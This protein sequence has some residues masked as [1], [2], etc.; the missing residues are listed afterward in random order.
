MNKRREQGASG[1][2]LAALASAVGL[3]LVWSVV[4]A[5]LPSWEE[6][7]SEQG[8]GP[9][10]PAVPELDLT[11]PGVSPHVPDAPSRS[12]KEGKEPVSKA[13]GGHLM[14]RTVRAGQVAEVKCAA[15]L[16]EACPDALTQEERYQCLV[17]R[18]NK[19]TAPCQALAQKRI[20][21]WKE[22]EGC[23]TACAEDVKQVCQGVAAEDGSLLACLQAREQ[24]LS[25]GCYQSLPKGQIQLRN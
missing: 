11:I 10:A 3:A 13:A 9:I 25:V 7:Q 21:R 6:L 15:E 2:S 1:K 8:R 16:Q 17:R 23:K 5:N 12:G 20:V 18:V 4:W 14:S 19:F 24:D 22:L